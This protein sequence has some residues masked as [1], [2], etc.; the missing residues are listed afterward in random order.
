MTEL[1]TRAQAFGLIAEGVAAGLSAPWRLYLAQGCR[2]LSLSVGDRTEWNAWRTHLGCP[3]LSVRVYDAGG[4]IRRS[5]VAEVVL[6]GCRISVELVEEVSTD[7]LDRLLVAD[8]TA[9]PTADS[10]TVEP[11]E[12]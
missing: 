12:R 11:E 2:Y 4:E 1:A 9:D 8:P 6:D 3:E 5:S 10:T 7:D